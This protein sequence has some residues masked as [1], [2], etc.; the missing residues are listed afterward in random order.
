MLRSPQDLK[1][2]NNYSVDS[3]GQAV[4]Y[5]GDNRKNQERALDYAQRTGAIPLEHT[6]A[7]RKLE[8]IY[9]RN[10][11]RYPKH[12]VKARRMSDQ[13]MTVASKRYA[14]NAHGNVKTF[15]C[16][17]RP[18]SVFRKTELR[19]L[20][21]NKKVTSI[22]GVARRHFEKAFKQDPSG[23]KAYHMVCRA[24]L[25]Q[26][27]YIGKKTEDKNLLADVDKRLNLYG[28]KFPRNKSNAPSPGTKP[29]T[30]TRSQTPPPP[31]SHKHSR[32][33]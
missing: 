19:A 10:L 8:G 32:K 3:Q 20:I 11:K 18:K 16:G 2:A 30:E 21:R 5:S 22:N 13:I 25:R 15:V 31:P 1:I 6:K 26:D 7:G 29:K 4:F 27:Q 17:A 24:E 14:Q 28:N 33:L 9:Q 23:N 12:P